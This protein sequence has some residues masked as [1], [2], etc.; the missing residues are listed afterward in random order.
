MYRRTLWLLLGSVCLAFIFVATTGPAV[1]AAAPSGPPIKVGVLVPQTGPL[2]ELGNDIKSGLTLAF[3]EVNWKI[4]GRE[5]KMI[6]E[7]TEAKPNVALQ[8]AKKLVESERVDLLAGIVHSGVAMAVRG[9]AD[10]QKI[11]IVITC[12]VADGLTKDNPSKYLFRTYYSS[13]MQAL[14]IAVHA[15][16]ELNIRKAYIAAQDYV[17]GHDVADSFKALFERLGGKVIGESYSP[18]G[19]TDFAPYLSKIKDVD[20]VWIF[21]PGSDGLQ[22]VKQYNEYG[23]KK[24]V[25]HLIGVSASFKG[26]MLDI[27]KDA[28]VGAYFS[29]VWG[30]SLNTPENQKFVG[31]YKKM[32][33]PSPP[34]DVLEGSYIGGQVIIRGIT[35]AK[36]NTKDVPALL[37]KN[38]TKLSPLSQPAWFTIS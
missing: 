15:Y 9:Y 29:S 35:N 14:P 24:K 10:E 11:P 4:A 32:A 3:E 13:G 20:A 33:R 28:G 23:L 31:A 25:P 8:K 27:H 6:I 21:E 17:T 5:V 26:Y 18:I 19:T 37:A 16:K 36:G 1:N 12:A 34:D 30:I 22:F 2:T 7:D 38:K